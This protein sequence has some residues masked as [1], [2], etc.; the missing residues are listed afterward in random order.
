MVQPAQLTRLER[1]SRLPSFDSW[2]MRMT[3]LTKRTP[4]QL[5]LF[6]LFSLLA[7]HSR[8]EGFLIFESKPK[9]RN[10]CKKL[11][12]VSYFFLGRFPP[13]HSLKLTNSC[14]RWLFPNFSSRMW[15]LCS[16]ILQ[17]SLS[18]FPK[19]VLCFDFLQFI[20]FLLALT[21]RIV[22]WRAF[23]PLNLNCLKDSA[24]WSDSSSDF[25]ESYRCF[26]KSV[27]IL[28]TLMINCISF[29]HRGRQ[30]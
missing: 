9:V 19:R 21:R 17:L 29:L 25:Q 23:C 20:S 7:T 8:F 2:E 28:S 27:G 24:L 22:L 16:R 4:T 1:H 6:H 15:K 18:Y 3:N 5:H 14:A 12:Y 11:Q 10:V 30:F 26:Q 13:L